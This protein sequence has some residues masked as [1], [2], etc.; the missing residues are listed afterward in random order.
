MAKPSSNR[1]LLDAALLKLKTRARQKA[2]APGLYHLGLDGIVSKFIG[3]TEK[4]LD[5]IFVTVER[6]GAVLLFDEAD[7]LF[8]KRSEVKDAHDRYANADAAHLISRFDDSWP[9]R[10]R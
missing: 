1:A 6:S 7:A 10:L 4:H 3:E 9:P 8:G 2:V 5:G